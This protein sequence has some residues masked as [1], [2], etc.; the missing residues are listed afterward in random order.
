MLDTRPKDPSQ[1]GPW[2]TFARPRIS[3]QATGTVYERYG[4]TMH[5]E[6]TLPFL[7]NS[8]NSFLQDPGVL[9]Y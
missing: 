6:R 9:T 1:K 4:R 3:R 7:V 8:S 5:P 2:S